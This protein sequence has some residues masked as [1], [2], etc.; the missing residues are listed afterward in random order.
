MSPLL[1]LHNKKIG[2]GDFSELLEIAK[3]AASSARAVHRRAL[4]HHDVK[5]AWQTL[6]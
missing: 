1:Q 4:D 6:H 2:L 5:A 3:R